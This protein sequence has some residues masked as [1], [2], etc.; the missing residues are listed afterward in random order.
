M[1]EEKTVS[2]IK[3]NVD[4]KTVT[5]PL[6][7]DQLRSLLASSSSLIDSDPEKVL[8]CFEKISE[9]IN[10][11]KK[12]NKK[13]V[14]EFCTKLNNALS[15]VALDT[16]YLAAETVDQKYRPLIIQ[17]ARDI[18][19]EYQC[20]TSS[21]KALVETIVI[22]YGRILE[23]SKLFNEAQHIE[24]LSDV[25]NGYYGMIAKELDRAYRQFASS[26]LILK[27]I[28]APVLEVNIK[29]K[30]AFIAQNQ[31]INTTSPV[32]SGN[33]QEHYENIDPK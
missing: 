15:V 21:E 10:G 24:F 8:E 25:K 18:V 4:T 14:A 31:Q 20:K 22:A 16:H 6:T 26:L 32:S 23:L 9:K 5:K 2:T 12:P 17:F 7:R 19:T 33:E 11:I 29:A 27:Q 28:K 13:L 30:T 1:L 3:N